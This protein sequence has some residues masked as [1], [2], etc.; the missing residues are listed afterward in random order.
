MKIFIRENL[1]HENFITRKFPGLRYLVEWGPIIL[2]Q[3]EKNQKRDAR[4]SMPKNNTNEVGMI[5]K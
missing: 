1:K 4:D 2:L 5:P 3:E